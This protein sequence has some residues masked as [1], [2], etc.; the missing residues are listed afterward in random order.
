M[1]A[2]QLLSEQGMSAFG[3]ARVR[4]ALLSGLSAVAMACAASLAFA[5]PWP[6]LSPEAPLKFGDVADASP[7]FAVFATGHI[8]G[9][10]TLEVSG[11]SEPKF[12]LA[13]VA[14]LGE[15]RPSR[16]TR[17]RSS[18]TPPRGL[19][20]RQFKARFKRPWCGWSREARSATR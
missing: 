6:I 15:A 20:S 4:T 16:T 19:R 10:P 11:L 8:A 18:T 12:D 17:R 13:P 3:R 7:L 5:D 1:Q 2:K 9:D 14:A